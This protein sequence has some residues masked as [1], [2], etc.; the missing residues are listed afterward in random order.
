MY[1]NVVYQLQARLQKYCND[2]N[3][4]KLCIILYLYAPINVSNY[5]IK[6]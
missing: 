1:K 6:N 2:A 3:Q 5:F 4:Q